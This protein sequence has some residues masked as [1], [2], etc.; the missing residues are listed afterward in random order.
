VNV[1]NLKLEKLAVLSTLEKPQFTVLSWHCV[2]INSFS[3][4]IGSCTRLNVWHVTFLGLIKPCVNLRW[5]GEGAASLKLPPDI[6]W[7]SPPASPAALQTDSSPLSLLAPNLSCSVPCCRSGLQTPSLPGD[8]HRGSWST[9]SFLSGLFSDYLH[10]F[11]LS[12][13]L[14]CQSCL[15]KRVINLNALNFHN[16]FLYWLTDFSCTSLFL[17]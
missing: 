1:Y 5:G 17:L 8:L 10:G 15:T 4:F 7:N 2:K 14:I 12:L 6:L 16:S 3:H 13:G 9:L 11:F